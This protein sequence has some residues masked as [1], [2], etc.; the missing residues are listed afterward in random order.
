MLLYSWET[1]SDLII[2]LM[3][4]LLAMVSAWS[5]IIASFGSS[6]QRKAVFLLGSLLVLLASFVF[7]HV[8]AASVD[9]EAAN[10]ILLYLYRIFVL[11]N[12]CV[13]LML[14]VGKRPSVFWISDK[15]AHK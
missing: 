12:G 13:T 10:G 9:S 3:Y 14:F 8:A 1:S 15:P 7:V 11:G 6:V 5:M 4:S 2:T